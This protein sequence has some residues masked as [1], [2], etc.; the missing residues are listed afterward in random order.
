MLEQKVTKGAS[1]E[2][3]YVPHHINHLDQILQE[4][5]VVIKITDVLSFVLRMSPITS[6]LGSQG[7]YN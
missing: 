7:E 2:F 6:A 4:S 5:P 3:Q 1:I